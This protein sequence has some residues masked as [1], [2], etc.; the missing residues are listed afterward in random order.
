[1][2]Q[3]QRFKIKGRGLELHQACGPYAELF[4][5]WSRVPPL[6]LS[7]AYYIV[8][9]KPDS[10]TLPTE[11]ARPNSEGPLHFCLKTGI[12]YK[13]RL[14][15][16][17][18]P[19][20]DIISEWSQIPDPDIVPQHENMLKLILSGEMLAHIRELSGEAPVDIYQ[21]GLH[22]HRCHGGSDVVYEIRDRPAAIEIHSGDR[23]RLIQVRTNL[24]RMTCVETIS[25]CFEP[26][27][28]R[29]FLSR[30]VQP[31]PSWRL[32]AELHTAQR[33]HHFWMQPFRDAFEESNP[34]HVIGCFRFYEDGNPVTDIR[35]WGFATR[36]QEPVIDRIQLQEWKLT[37]VKPVRALKLQLQITSAHREMYK[38]VLQEKTITDDSLQAVIG[39]SSTEIAAA[40]RTLFETDRH[41]D[42]DQSFLELVLW[43]KADG[44][45]WQ[46]FQRDIAQTWRWD[47]I[48]S[49]AATSCDCEWVLIDIEH[50]DRSLAVLRSGAEKRVRWPAGIYLRP[51]SQRRL[52]V[53]WD[54]NRQV[55][56]N[57]VREQWGV[58]LREVG[59]YLKV[60]EE[61]LGQRHRRADLDIHLLELFASHQNAYFDVDPD[62]CIAVEI[63]ARH[64]EK[65]LALTAVSKPIVTPRIPAGETA[66]CSQ[67]AYVSGRG[68]HC[69][70]RE[71]RHRRGSDANNLARVMLHL[72]LH[73][74]NLYRVEPFRER[75]LKDATWPV[76]TQDGAEVHNPPGE[77]VLRNCLDSWLPV[78][79]TLRILAAE[80]IDFQ[81]SLDISPPAAYMLCSPRFKDYMSRY[82]MR[83]KA[84]VRGQMALMRSR[85]DPEAY[86]YAAEQYLAGIQA[87][88]W[89]YTH[90]LNKDI[91]GAFRDLELKGYLEISTCTATHGMPAELESVPDALKSQ[92]T[93]A[94]RSHHR[95]FGDRPRGIWL[96]ENS[97]FPGLES[98]LDQEGLAYFFV[99]AEA[100][101]AASERPSEEEFNPVALPGFNLAAFGRS[102][103][104]RTQVWDADIGYAGHPDFREYHFRH[105]GLPL[106]R[107][108]SKISDDKIPYDPERAIHTA[109]L[110]AQDFYNKLTQKAETLKHREFKSIPL[111]TCSYDAEL[112]GHHWSEG[113]VFLEEL[114]RECYRKSDVIGLTTPSHYLAADP[115]LPRTV[116]N[117][118]TWGH[119]ALHVKW[120][121]PKVAWTFREIERGDWLLREYLALALN[122]RLSGFQIRAV[123]QMAAELIRAQSSDLTFV[124]MAGDFEED[125]QR[126]ILKYLDYFY[127]LKSI[128]DT[129]T[130]DEAFLRFRQYE[131]DMFPEIPPFYN[132]RPDSYPSA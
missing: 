67:Y 130:E 63:V 62:T 55:V 13:L 44:H 70:Q 51:F 121:D 14:L 80:G 87:I 68:Y 132:I 60:H 126:E 92:I 115:E 69:S 125:M 39:F 109:R 104:G 122:G 28:L 22:I 6:D 27:P 74:P 4:F 19:H 3:A 35:Q 49:S 90:E 89:F 88:E 40:Q 46:E 31:D 93:L 23:G 57:T 127:R 99:E 16:V 85:K 7:E 65:E 79:R 108:T 34:D 52:L 32:R 81:L 54:L 131:N 119:D 129:G 47:H 123:E 24:Q 118:S 20:F 101:L 116:P 113:P 111:I 45:D 117:P 75:F 8:E 106:K 15:A 36:I 95:I 38:F 91:V 53:C 105:L 9:L 5:D 114:L 12:N 96:A 17:P 50:P 128:I 86:W 56:E 100:V 48:P 120:S 110:L 26:E 33:F 98:L 124:I 73:S 64:H 43:F 78:L 29:L 76:M 107:I 18:H 97:Y 41:V 94:A 83:Q 102:R 84:Y 66:G 42:W 10:A 11:L 103:L 72:H 71:V 112:F 37:H 59:F 25:F 61:Y 1:M 30:A 77:W 21:D 58:D 2:S 82:L